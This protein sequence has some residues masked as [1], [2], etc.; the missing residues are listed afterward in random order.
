MDIT[1]TSNLEI[2][3]KVKVILG[4][5]QDEPQIQLGK[6][7]AV[8]E[9]GEALIDCGDGPLLSVPQEHIREPDHTGGFSMDTYWPTS[10]ARDGRIICKLIEIDF[11][12]VD[13]NE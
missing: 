5:D 13:E 6:I 2:G 11:E 12:Y 4:A 3:R 9:F 1:I 10:K 8:S 7:I